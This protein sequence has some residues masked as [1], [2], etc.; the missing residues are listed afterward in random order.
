M[1]SIPVASASSSTT[2]STAYSEMG[3]PGARYAATLG[4]LVTTS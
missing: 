2:A 1:G 3:A 4:R